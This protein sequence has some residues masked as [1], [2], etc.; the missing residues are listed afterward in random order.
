MKR[1]FR[2]TGNDAI[3]DRLYRAIVQASRHEALYRD[4]AVPDTLDGRFESLVLHAVLV[5][6]RL[7]A[8][9]PPGPDVAQHLVDTIFK[10]FD[11]AMR[12]MGVGDTAVPKRMKTMAE[13]FLGRSSA[14]EATLRAGPDALA[15]A[16][17][18]NVYSGSRDGA[19]L[20]RY[21][22]ANAA[23]L[24]QTPLQSFI[25]GAVPFVDPAAFA[26]EVAP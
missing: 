7:G 12:E 13:A 1:F 15:K 18:R 22:A 25:D 20:A 19:G 3:V 17:A 10:H 2:G 11:R 14:Y 5:L 16:L 6:R 9:A 24:N 26:T 8:C 21:M 23:A 4:H